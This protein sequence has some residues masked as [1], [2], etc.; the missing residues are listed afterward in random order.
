MTLATVQA[1]N[2]R[3]ASTTGT[4]ETSFIIDPRTP[5]RRI[6][7]EG[8]H[9]RRR[10]LALR[11]RRARLS[12]SGARGAWA[13]NG[14]SGWIRLLQEARLALR[15]L[16][17]ANDA[18]RAR[19]NA[20]YHYD[21]DSGIYQLFLDADLQYSC[22]YFERAGESLEEAQLAKKRHI[23]AQAINPGERV[24]DIGSGFGGLANYLARFCGASVTGLTLSKAQFD[25]SRSRAGHRPPFFPAILAP[26]PRCFRRSSEAASCRRH[27]VPRLPY[28]ETLRAWRERFL[29][30]REEAKEIT[31]ERFCRM[32]EL[33]LA[34]SEASFQPTKA[35]SSSS[36]SWRRSSADADYIGRA[37][38]DLR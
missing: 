15:R 28:A 30:R 4:A 34:G 33:Y 27:R 29:K 22:G 25:I 23:A 35:S 18:L 19:S 16:G 8:P 11:G 21:I 38:A 6:I 36:Y 26:F 37:E 7:D 24:L 12:K 13:W 20:A 1:K 9:R 31:D 10:R 5:V 14:G 32:W 3:S 2:W 17:R